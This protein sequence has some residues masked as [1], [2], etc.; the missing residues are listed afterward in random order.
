MQLGHRLHE[1][2]QQC[3]TLAQANGLGAARTQRLAD[4]EH[5]LQP[6][7]Q[8]LHDRGHVLPR[9]GGARLAGPGHQAQPAI[10]KRSPI[11]PF[12]HCM[13]CAGG[14]NCLSACRFKARIA[15][16]SDL[17]FGTWPT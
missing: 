17:T 12:R 4:I 8:R 16:P 5:Q 13:H 14:W 2:L 6:Q 11:R 10:L 15:Q 1:Q 9:R 7:L 3:C